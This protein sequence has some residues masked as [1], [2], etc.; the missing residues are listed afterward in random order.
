[1]RHDCWV[2]DKDSSN[3]IQNN[4]ATGQDRVRSWV[5]SK[6]GCLVGLLVGWEIGKVVG[7]RLHRGL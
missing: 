1:M 2:K 3:S 7:F 5:G 4:S 6:L